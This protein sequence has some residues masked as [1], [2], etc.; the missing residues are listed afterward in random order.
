[1]SE[2]AV[3]KLKRGAT[4]V[5]KSGSDAALDDEIDAKRALLKKMKKKGSATSDSEEE[6]EL[7]SVDEE[8]E[9]EDEDEEDEEQGDIEDD[10]DVEEEDEEEQEGEEEDEEAG[11]SE[12][13]EDE[14]EDVEAEEDEDNDNSEEDSDGEEE[15]GDGD[16]D[17]DEDE[18][19]EEDDEDS[20]SE[21]D[22]PNTKGKVEPTPKKRPDLYGRDLPTP[23]SLMAAA[24]DSSTVSSQASLAGE[25]S[26]PGK[27][28]PPHL[29][30]LMQQQQQGASGS[31]SSSSSTT[32]ASSTPSGPSAEA[33]QRLRRQVNGQLNKL[34]VENADAVLKELRKLGD[35]T[36]KGDLL[37]ALVHCVIETILTMPRTQRVTVLADAALVACLHRMD[38]AH[39]GSAF[40]EAVVRELQV[41]INRDESKAADNGDA[42]QPPEMPSDAA[43]ATAQNLVVLLCG[44]YAF[45]VV[46]C[47]LVMDALSTIALECK[48]WPLAAEMLVAGL[49]YA[50][51]DIRKDDPA[52]LKSTLPHRSCPH[53]YITFCNRWTLL[54]T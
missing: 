47:Q 46:G 10:E 19:D 22:V 24:T 44:L 53:D 41:V 20:E 52:A 15:D 21:S 54:S 27:Y 6:A 13:E 33:T 11:E 7:E 35:A 23:S 26:G 9:D 4:K 25:A 5:V 2:F 49:D 38:G 36:S 37:N 40:M 14:D 28:V 29:R 16:G 45:K 8:D 31:S 51:I 18:E 43:I 50:G 34:T 32:S 48:N 1:M 30:K 12:V 42:D 3:Q 17:G 39:V